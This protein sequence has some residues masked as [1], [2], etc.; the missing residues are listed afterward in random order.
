M[1]FSEKTVDQRKTTAKAV[2]AVPAAHRPELLALNLQ[3]LAVANRKYGFDVHIY[4]DS[5]D[6][7]RLREIEQ[8][9]DLF[10]PEA[11][12][13]RARPHVKAYS[14]SWNI[15][16][17]IKTSARFAENVYL[18][19]E[20]VMVYPYFFDW[21]EAQTAPASCGRRST[22]GRFHEKHGDA[23]RNP[24]SCLRR[25]LLDL[26]IPH[27]NDDYYTDQE[28]YCKAQGF[29]T[30]KYGSVD[31][32]LICYVLEAAG[33]QAVYPD[34]PVC[35]HQGFFHYGKLDIYA[36][37]PGL[38]IHQRIERAREIQKAVLTSP[39]PRHKRYASDFEPYQP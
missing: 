13:F 26:L 32:G 16:Q 4:A 28:G 1:I 2:I 21:H 9:R 35:A 36:I 12:L 20:D 38:D 39:D 7:I 15:L 17:S 5:V 31:D 19:E 24:G 3:R 34:K 18:I 25:P 23:Y 6:E 37:E 30:D 10:Y 27:I 33:M 22:L 29:P 14:G 11:F 8:V